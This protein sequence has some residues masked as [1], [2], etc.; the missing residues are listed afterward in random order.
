[1]SLLLFAA[2]AAASL[3]FARWRSRV[4]KAR[5]GEADVSEDGPTSLF[6]R[7]GALIVLL[8]ILMLH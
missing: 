1:M 2:W 8:L 4:L 5:T 6:V 7:G 3:L